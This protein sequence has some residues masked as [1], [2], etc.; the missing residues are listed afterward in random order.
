[1]RISL[2]AQVHS[3]IFGSDSQYQKMELYTRQHAKLTRNLPL[4]LK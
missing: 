3:N 1:M 4:F 2:A